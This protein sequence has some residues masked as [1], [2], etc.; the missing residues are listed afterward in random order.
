V[1]SDGDGQG[2]SILRLSIYA[3][4]HAEYSR[5]PNRWNPGR[6]LLPRRGV[7]VYRPAGA[8]IAHQIGCDGY[9]F[10]QPSSPM[11]MIG[12]ELAR[13]QVL[14]AASLVREMLTHP[15]VAPDPLT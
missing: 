11:M 5:S 13:N 14:H 7:G 1:S 10:S 9:P 3:V 15:S 2:G 12:L 8:L 4:E 6:Q